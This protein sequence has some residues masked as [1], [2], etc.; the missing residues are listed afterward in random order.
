MRAWKPSGKGGLSD[1]AESVG[2][3]SALMS[4]HAAA[5]DRFRNGKR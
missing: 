5:A 4:P 3:L 2:P 1:I